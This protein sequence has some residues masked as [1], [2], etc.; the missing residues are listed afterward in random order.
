LSNP[1]RRWIIL[2]NTVAQFAGRNF[3]ALGRLVVAGV[4]VRSYGTLTFAE[5][6]VVIGIL[7]IAEWFVDFG[8]TEVF[9]REIC[10]DP[11]KEQRLLRIVTAAKAI[12][13]PVALTALVTLMLALRYP[14]EIVKAGLV[15]GL[16]LIF[17]A[18]VMVYRVIF[19]ASLTMQREVTAELL[20]VLA[21]IPL[22]VVARQYGGG[23]TALLL[24]HVASRA[25]FC[26]LCFLLGRRSY[27]PSVRG[28]IWRDVDWG[29]RSSLVIGGIGFLV[30][31]Y[32]AADVLLLSKLGGLSELAYYSGAQKL[33]WPL[34]LGLA[35]IGGTLYPVAASYWPHSRVRFEEACQQGLDTVLVLA[36]FAIC[37]V[38]AG[39]EFFMGLLGPDLK[40][41]A[42]ALRV[43]ALLC[44][45]KVITATLGPILY[46][47]HAQ[48]QAL[49]FIATALVVKIAVIAILVPRLGYMGVAY[50]AV[51]VE[52][53]FAAVP[54]VYLLRKL[55]GYR[56]RWEVPIKVAAITIAAAAVARLL[57]SAGGLPAAIAALIVY[58][59]LVFLVGA[60]RFS[61][62]HSLLR[63]KTP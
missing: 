21:M 34:L 54:T 50:G 6:S 2:K 1:D 22:V 61:E 32:E 53:F 25:I 56:V 28:V 37:A 52:L 49:Q 31:V 14:S 15:G 16:S 18:G 8:T 47:V 59:P 13:I 46:V 40:A 24:C 55:A 5:Y 63:W 39:A 23:L 58:S 4:V 7:A 60:V 48:K 9:V 38:L 43:L 62:I 30:G 45:I 51:I 17:F 42:P 20:S 10:R 44:F 19:K 29:L 33:I 27:Q 36:G 12:Q 41:G 26:S 11:E 3:I 35:S 57:P